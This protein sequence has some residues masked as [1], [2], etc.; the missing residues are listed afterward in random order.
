LLSSHEEIRKKWMYTIYL[1]SIFRRSMNSKSL[2][3]GKKN[4]NKTGEGRRLEI[5]RCRDRRKSLTWNGFE[6]KKES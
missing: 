2:L 6:K 3:L 1:L 4:Q 5:E